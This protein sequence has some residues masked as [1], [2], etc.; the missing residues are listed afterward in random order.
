MNIALVNELKM[1]FDKMDIDIWE[2]LDAAATKPFGFHRFSP[3]PG[4]GGHCIPVDPFYLAHRARSFGMEAHF[5]QRAGEINVR[6]PS[7]VVTKVR[8]QIATKLHSAEAF[9]Q[10]CPA[11][12][13]AQQRVTCVLQVTLALNDRCKAVNGARI[14]I[15]GVAYKVRLPIQ[16]NLAFKHSQKHLRMRAA[17]TNTAR[18]VVS[19]STWPQANMADCRETPAFHVWMLLKEMGAH[20]CYHDPFVPEIKVTFP[21]G[22]MSATTTAS[23]CNRRVCVFVFCCL[24]FRQGEGRSHA[25]LNGIRSVGMKEGLASADV[26]AR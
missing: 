8:D 15:I 6:M 16:S 2:V 23:P 7:Y 24:L 3:G 17:I 22:S 20:V 13:H 4:W 26:S 9:S 5:I 12:A 1:I 19:P 25:Q 14:L 11:V 10:R 21:T 18:A